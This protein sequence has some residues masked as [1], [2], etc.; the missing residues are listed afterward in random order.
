MS[1]RLMIAAACVASLLSTVA[2]G[3]DD[4]KFPGMWATA[5]VGTMVKYK[6]MGG[7]T[8]THE[9]IKADEA[10][11]TIRSTTSMPNMPEGTIPP[12]ERVEPRYYKADPM[13]ADKP[14]NV[15]V[16]KKDN[17]TLEVAG[18]KLNCEVY[19]TEMTM[20]GKTIK[21]IAYVCRDV[22]GGM[23]KTESNAMGEMQVM[24]E[25]VEF[26]K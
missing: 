12:Q 26:K 17:Q 22:P 15:K 20:E 14:A 24:M 8:S 19:E 5:K 4:K 2:R 10:T 1:M 25:L 13:T 7:M 18:Q 3:Q 6:M 16:T 9:V 11:V 21:S 23:V